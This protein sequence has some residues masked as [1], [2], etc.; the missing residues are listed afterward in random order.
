MMKFSF[1]YFYLLVCCLL[2]SNT[3]WAG[4]INQNPPNVILILTD[5]LGIGDLGCEGNPWLKTPNI[6]A[7]YDESVRMTDFHTSPLCT[8]TRAAIITGK[9]PINNGAW[10]TFKGRDALT[11]NTKTMADVFKQNGYKTAMFGKWHLGDNYPTR[12]TDMGFE[13]ATHHLAGG[14]GELSDYWG[15]SYFDDVYYVNNKPKQF[16]GYCTDVWFEESTK[17]IK[18]NKEK[19]F[20]LY[21]PTNAP[22]DPLIVAEK[23]AAPY[24]KLEG[25]DIISANLYGM[26][27]NIDENFGKFHQ[28][29]EN[30]KLL[31]NTIL[32]F[33]SDNGTRFGYSKDGKLGYNKGYRGIKGSKQEG[34][35]R[36][37][38]FIRWPNGNVQGGKDINSLAEHVDLIPTLAGLCNLK[39]PKGMNLD[40]QDFSPLLTGE[41]NKLKSKVGFIHHRQDWRQPKD[42]DQ[43]CI[44]KNQ[45]RLING[46]ELY[47]IEK[48]P[49]Q[50]TNLADKYPK[51]VSELLKKNAKFL[52]RVKENREYYELPFSVVGNEAQKEIKLTIQHAIGE[53]SGIWKPEQVAAG[54][55]NTNNKH[56]LKV[57][58]AGLYQISCRRWP[59][60]CPGPILGIPTENPKNLF[61]YETI[62]PE[63]VR[64]SIANQMLEKDIKEDE[65]EVLFTVKLEKGKTILENDFIEGKSKYGVYYTYVKYLGE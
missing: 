19:P 6:D 61:K 7:F 53:D 17:F 51:I 49:K 55:K 34:G 50:R 39:I 59:K 15:N 40:G 30:E 46:N 18:K 1:N 56:A 23:Y 3:I 32:I 20:F 63:K 47:D 37:P 21:L 43:T 64:I 62:S 25:K 41:K 57:E 4:K 44:M 60:E 14:V 31:E 12:P 9:Y 16:E 5:D 42:V 36:V 45:W 52:E 65:A 38:F 10:A 35:H 28:F 48:D 22:H 2:I 24:K 26:I 33:M 58:K 11:Q 27:A 29:L 13:T 54:M 8:P